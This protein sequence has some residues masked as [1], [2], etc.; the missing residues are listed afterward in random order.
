MYDLLKSPV[1][2][3]GGGLALSQF[4]RVRLGLERNIRM[5]HDYYRNNPRYLNSS[6]FLVKL[7]AAFNVS[8]RLD[9]DIFV[10]KIDDWSMDLA[11]AL[12]MTSATYRG[13]LFKPGHFYGPLVNE[14]IIA[15]ADPFD[16]KEAAANWPDLQPIRV[17]AHPFSDVDMAIPNGKSHTQEGG[18]AVITINIP[19]LALQYKCWRRQDLARVNETPQ[20]IM[21]FISEFPLPNMIESQTN[22]A[23]LNRAMVAFFG[24][25]TPRPQSAHPFYMTNWGDEIDRAVAYWFKFVSGKSL[26]FPEMLLSLPTVG[27]NDMLR[28]L[29]LPAESFTM[30]L[31]WA[32]VMARLPLTTFLVQFNADDQN[33]NNQSVLNYLRRWIDLVEINRSMEAAL[34]AEEFNQA[35]YIINNGIRPYLQ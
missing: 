3:R 11:M 21:Q 32:V 34:P 6:H 33:R 7:I 35:M 4:D 5:I 15:N 29:Q 24:G 10:G 17:L 9:D 16:V 14:V 26:R 25:R 18:I 31:Q 1:N 27:R 23:I 22:I 13:K 8:H 20:T 28:T 19:M 2:S 12:K 30:Q